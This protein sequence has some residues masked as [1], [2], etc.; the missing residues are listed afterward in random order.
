LYA[1]LFSGCNFNDDIEPVYGGDV[2]QDFAWRTY[3][4]QEDETVFPT[5]MPYPNPT[6]Q[7]P[8]TRYNY[9]EDFTDS[10]HPSMGNTKSNTSQHPNEMSQEDLYAGCKIC[11]EE[12]AFKNDKAAVQCLKC[13]RFICELCYESIKEKADLVHSHN[14]HNGWEIP[15]KTQFKCPYCNNPYE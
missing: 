6:N 3:D 15:Y 13:K 14:Y 5:G 7:F 8:N 9:N 4:K 12:D 11:F 2:F 1:C 10:C